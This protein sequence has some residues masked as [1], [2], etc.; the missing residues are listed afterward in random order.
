MTREEDDT[1]LEMLHQHYDIGMTHAQIAAMHGVTKTAV[2]QRI[3]R[4]RESDTAHD[5]EAAE[6]WQRQGAST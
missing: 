4:V 6:Y 1:L 3:K 2:T 5:P